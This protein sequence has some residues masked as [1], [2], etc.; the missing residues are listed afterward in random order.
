M[1]GEGLGLETFLVVVLLGCAPVDE[2]LLLGPV[3]DLVDKLL[4]SRG[5][6]HD[7]L[8]VEVEPAEVVLMLFK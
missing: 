3:G 7:L 1:D 4:L 5:E 2:V 8:V 6:L